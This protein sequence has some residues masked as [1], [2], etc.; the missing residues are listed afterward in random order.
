MFRDINLWTNDGIKKKIDGK[1]VILHSYEEVRKFV[2]LDSDNDLRFYRYDPEYV[3]HTVYK[4][5][6]A[7]EIVR[8]PKYASIDNDGI[9]GR[10]ED[11]KTIRVF[12]QMINKIVEPYEE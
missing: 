9:I 10:R 6:Y 4:R 8:F 7:E 3:H 5:D 2:E 12:F 1:I 11:G